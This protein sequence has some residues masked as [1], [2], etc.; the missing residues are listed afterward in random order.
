MA[1][2]VLYQPQSFAPAYNRNEYKIDSTNKAEV[3]FRY[4]VDV[5]QAGTAN[6][7]AEWRVRP[8][9]ITLEGIVDVRKI[10]TTL[11]SYDF[12]PTLTLYGF[13]NNQTWDAY[14]IKFGEEY[15]V[16]YNYTGFN[17]NGGYV[18]LT[19]VD[20]HSYVAGDLINIE[21]STPGTNPLMT[22]LHSIIS[23]TASTITI[24]VIYAD[25]ISPTSIAGIVTYADNRKTIFRDLTTIANQVVFNGVFSWQDFKNYD[26]EDYDLDNIADKFLTSL[27]AGQANSFKTSPTA[28]M[29]VNLYNAKSAAIQYMMFENS[30]GD[31][32]YKQITNTVDEVN[33]V[34][35]GASNNNATF[36]TVGLPPLVKSDT[37]WYKFWFADNTFTRLSA[38]YYVDIDRRCEIEPFEI[39]FQDRKGS[40]L[41]FAF[42][43]KALEEVSVDRT[44]INQRVDGFDGGTEWDY[45]THENGLIAVSTEIDKEYTLNTNWM[46]Q[47]DNVI[48]QELVTSPKTLIKL[49]DGNWYSCIVKEKDVEVV[50]ERG[51][52]LIRKTIKIELSN[53]D[54][55]NG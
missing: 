18:R 24:D 39:L 53:K 40:F 17:D 3:G 48:F 52:K 38:E 33:I 46:T 25:M 2:S 29:Y 47:R 32:L 19:G 41:P 14:D 15:K 50:R 49:E 54:T 7:I 13:N 8:L 55:V 20:P 31:V 37:T 30:N 36:A 16:D 9:P 35:V 28:E 12:D 51:R 21:E 10:I 43:L 11:L 5:Y 26:M 4:V 27:N 44:L 1:I 34:P 6:K 42:N 45:D 23:V 22:G